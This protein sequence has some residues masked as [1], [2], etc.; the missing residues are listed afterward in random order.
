MTGDQIPAD[1]VEKV[2]ELSRLATELVRSLS[3]NLRDVEDELLASDWC[4]ANT[5][6]D[7]LTTLALE[8]EWRRRG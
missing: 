6:A 7:R 3:E 8:L 4:T 2:E 1:V 5:L